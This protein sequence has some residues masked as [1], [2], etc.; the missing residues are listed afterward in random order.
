MAVQF[1]GFSS[2][3]QI[4]VGPI[5]HDPGTCYAGYLT[6]VTLT[7]PGSLPDMHFHVTAPSLEA[8]LAIV[9]AY[10]TTAGSVIIRILNATAGN[11]DPASQSF[12]V[13]GL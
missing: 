11:I 3:P 8:D 10:C 13:L 4:T 1:Q 2:I 12:Y 7:V 9:A 6:E 5:T